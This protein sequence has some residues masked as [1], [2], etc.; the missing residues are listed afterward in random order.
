MVIKISQ[1]CQFG[2]T[3]EDI[4]FVLFLLQ[5][6]DWVEQGKVDLMKTQDSQ[7]EMNTGMINKLDDIET[8]ETPTKYIGPLIVNF[9]FQRS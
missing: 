2:R 5:E 6:V 9:S 4:K 8:W 3:F 7:E 1:A